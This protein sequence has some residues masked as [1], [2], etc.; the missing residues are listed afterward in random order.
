[1][2]KWKDIEFYDWCNVIKFI[3]GEKL[4]EFKIVPLTKILGESY[5]VIYKENK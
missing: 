3:N 2:S 4:T 1:M 5:M